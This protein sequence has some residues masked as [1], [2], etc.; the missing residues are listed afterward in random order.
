[1]IVE[2]IE[3][4]KLPRQRE[5]RRRS[6]NMLCAEDFPRQIGPVTVFADRRSGRD[7]RKCQ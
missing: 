6:L 5:D 3:I 7:R 4:D 1:M 2:R